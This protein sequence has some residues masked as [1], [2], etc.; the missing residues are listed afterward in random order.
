MLCQCTSPLISLDSYKKCINEYNQKSLMTIEYLKD[1]IWKNN[2]ALNYDYPNHPK[3]QDLSKEFFKITFG[4]VI[5]DK[6][7]YLKYNNLVTPNTNFID[8]PRSE[9]VDI[10]D[11]IDFKLAENLFNEEK[12]ATQF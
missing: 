2:K 8:I 1:Y 7:E 11:E 4:I 12:Y 10:D 5:I 3:S 9:S 6:K